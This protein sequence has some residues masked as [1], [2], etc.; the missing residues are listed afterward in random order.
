MIANILLVITI[1]F[2]FALA[3]LSSKPMPGGDYGVGYAYAWIIYISGFIITSGLLAWNMNWNHCFDWISKYRNWLVFLGWLIFVAAVT[4]SVEYQN[5]WPEGKFPVFM[6]WL[7]ITRIYIWLPMLVF[8]SCFYLINASRLP[9]LSFYWM[10][11]M[12]LFGCFFSCIL[13]LGLI[14]TYG[15]YQVSQRLSLLQNMKNWQ[16]E[17]DASYKE[18]LN[19]ITNYNDS[20]IE[21]LL[22]FVELGNEEKR[23]QLAIAKIKSFPDWENELIKVLTKK[24]LDQIFIYH[25]ETYY[26]YA[27]LDGNSVP[28]PERFVKPFIYSLNIM[29]IRARKDLNDAYA[30]DIG[31]LN[32]IT[33]CKVF[34][35]Q[36]KPYA[37]ELRPAMLKLNEALS[38]EAKE[39]MNEERKRRYEKVLKMFRKEVK[40]WLKENT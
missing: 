8:I 24:D 5:K 16:I 3:N 7:T 15:K 32:L 11:N 28:H 25:D 38:G 37:K 12:L 2:Y 20:T 22:K 35:G 39:R 34:N 9:A 23:R 31:M 6:H 27:F 4:F 1:L 18:S 13:S 30:W 29:T 26:V 21:G 14:W 40:N 33:V 17:R 10:K 19:F 36:F